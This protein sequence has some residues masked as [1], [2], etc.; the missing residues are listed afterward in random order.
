[1]RYLAFSSRNRKEILR[2][3]LSMVFGVGFPVVLILLISIMQQ[4]MVGMPVDIFG[5]DSFAPGMA[6]FGLSFIPLFL[7]ML[8]ANDRDS[9]FLMRL[10]ASPLTAFD[11]IMGYSLPLIPVAVI[12]SAVCFGAA[13]LFGLPISVNIL[14]AVVVLIPIAALFIGFGL[15]SGSCLTGSQVGGISSI[16]I[17]VA[18]WLSGTWFSLE[19]IGGTFE[20]ICHALPFAHAVDAVEAAVQGEY[21]L[22]LPH[23]LWVIGYAAGLYFVAVYVFKK[24]MRS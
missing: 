6:V 14:L 1:M 11:Y 10:F 18:A 7:G 17:N 20:A 3:P 9:A 8:I 21:T 19:L 23:L 12:Q 24:K 16:L 2:D 13:F 4:S 5:I 22:I 15:L